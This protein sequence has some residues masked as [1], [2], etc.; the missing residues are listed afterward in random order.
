MYLPSKI[1]YCPEKSHACLCIFCCFWGSTCA[2]LWLLEVL[3]ICRVD[4]VSE[5]AAVQVFFALQTS[6]RAPLWPYVVIQESVRP[7]SQALFEPM[8]P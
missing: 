6:L 5:A 7:Q 3:A 4:N 8:Q 1:L 2:C